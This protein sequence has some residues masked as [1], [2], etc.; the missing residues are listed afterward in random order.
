[1]IS[2]PITI[3]LFRGLAD[4]EDT[5]RGWL[6]HRLPLAARATIRRSA[7]L[8][9]GVATLRCAVGVPHGRD[10]DR[11]RLRPHPHG[12]DRGPGAAGRCR[13]PRRRRANDAAGDDSGGDVVRVDPATG[14]VQVE[15]GPVATIRFDGLAPD[16]KTSRSGCPTRNAPN[17]WAAYRRADHP[18]PRRAERWVHHGS[19]ISQ[20]SNAA[21]S[22]HGVAGDRR[23][24]CRRRPR[25]PRPVG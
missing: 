10:G 12:A 1:M 7:A 5:A 22:Q 6:P 9:R 11:A 19:S 18:P 4:L 16:E 17:S 21:E 23:G 15:P 25:Q 13:R 20:G 14:A 3:E 24:R 8:Q 2:H